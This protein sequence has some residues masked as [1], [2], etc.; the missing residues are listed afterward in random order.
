MRRRAFFDV[1]KLVIDDVPQ[2]WM[3]ELAFPAIYDRKLHNVIE[4]GT[5]VH[6]C[7]DDVFLA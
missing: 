7:F 1:Q 6:A 4:T 5:G 2:I 3:M